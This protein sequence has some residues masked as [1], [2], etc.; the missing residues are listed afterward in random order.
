MALTGCW[1]R[2]KWK[3]RKEETKIS[4]TCWPVGT[5]KSLSKVFCGCKAELV[6]FFGFLDGKVNFLEFQLG[7]RW[8]NS[9]LLYL[10]VVHD[11]WCVL[12]YFW[13]QKVRKS[14]GSNIFSKFRLLFGW[15]LANL[16]LWWL[17]VNFLDFLAWSYWFLL[18]N[19]LK[20]CNI[21]L[22]LFQKR[23]F[24]TIVHQFPSIFHPKN[25]QCFD[26]FSLISPEKKYELRCQLWE[27][28]FLSSA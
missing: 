13:L 5:F 14:F 1:L 2:E 22:K 17:F 8:R 20:N 9:I 6:L 28:F 25:K 27:F 3:R 16:K 10:K 21:A 11:N 24:S 4:C 23:S 19:F 15:K 26:T 7:F 12:G 18:Q